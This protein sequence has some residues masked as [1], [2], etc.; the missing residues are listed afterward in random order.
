MAKP[1]P[2]R[3]RQGKTS[4][5]RIKRAKTRLVRTSKARTA[6]RAKLAKP[7]KARASRNSRNDQGSSE[8]R[9]RPL[10]V[11]AASVSKT[12]TCPIQAGGRQF[13]GLLAFGVSLYFPRSS[14]NQIVG[15]VN[16]LSGS[17]LVP[18]PAPTTSVFP[19]SSTRPQ[20]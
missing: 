6:D 3:T 10:K 1:R 8:V 15:R 13:G 19:F 17:K 20:A 16:S 7:A 4:Q 9:A 12:D 14:I 11:R 5:A 2:A 18:R